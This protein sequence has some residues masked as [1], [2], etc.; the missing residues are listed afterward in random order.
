MKANQVA[1]G[2][3][4]VQIT[5]EDKRKLAYIAREFKIQK[6]LPPHGKWKDMSS[7]EIW[8]AILIQFCVGGS[9]R[10]I[11]ELKKN[12]ERYDEFLEKLSFGTLL[13]VKS[14]RQEFIAGRL[15]DFKATRFHNKVAKGLNDCLENEDITRDGRIIF[16][17][18]LKNSRLNEDQMRDILLK[19]LP[20]FKM[21]SV[22]DFM[23]TIG[24]SRNF[25]AFDTRVVGLLNRHFGLDIEP[26]KVQSN[27]GL[28]KALEKELREVCQELGIELSLLDRILFNRNSEIESMLDSNYN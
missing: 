4:R 6:P 24:A 5:N 19:K 14:N 23:I 3:W 16:L 20:F 9:A 17:E 28:Y 10:R 13:R 26:G 7:E 12:R 8:K 15:Q 11:E 22:S 21:K 18:G 25:I 27:R 1:K 2:D